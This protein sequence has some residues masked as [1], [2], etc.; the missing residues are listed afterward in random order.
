[1]NS[2]APGSSGYKVTDYTGVSSKTN[3]RGTAL[4]V[5]NDIRQQVGNTYRK[6]RGGKGPWR[7][8]MRAG[9]KYNRA[10]RSNYVKDNGD[11]YM[12]FFFSML[13][14]LN[15]WTNQ[16]WQHSNQE[17]TQVCNS[18]I[19]TAPSSVKNFETLLIFSFL[20][21]RMLCSS[22]MLQSNGNWLSKG[23]AIIT[24]IHSFQRLI[25]RTESIIKIQ[26]KF[27][28]FSEISSLTSR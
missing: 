27:A 10:N 21:S 1:M 24:K 3:R 18:T 11:Q 8:R 14:D 23:N 4:Q 6:V 12:T 17:K 5:A 16:N 9:Y 19:D 2:E 22:K 26:N 20:L 25:M 13:G 28:I 7:E 15:I